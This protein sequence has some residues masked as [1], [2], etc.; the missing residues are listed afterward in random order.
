M[1]KEPIPPYESRAWRRAAARR[2]GNTAIA[3]EAPPHLASLHRLLTSVERGNTPA[4][5]TVTAA[6]RALRAIEHLILGTAPE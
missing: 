6:R 3:G 2:G 5:A 1:S 4:V